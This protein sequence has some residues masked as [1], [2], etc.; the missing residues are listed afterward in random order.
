MGLIWPILAVV[1]LWAL[2]RLGRQGER[3]GR[4]HWRIA[5][6][7]LGAVLIAAAVVAGSHGA[8]IGAGAAA[9]GGL[10][11]IVSSRLRPIV[12][13]P[14]GGREALSEAEARSILGVSAEA[15][16]ADIQTA[17]RRLMARVHP[18]QGGAEGLAAKLNAARDR[19]LKR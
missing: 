10:Y 13:P 18:D 2:V 14:G 7:V 8:W 12:R 11:L 4:G 15:S 5:A 6:T 17:W 16:E 9:V 1:A 19:L 3:P